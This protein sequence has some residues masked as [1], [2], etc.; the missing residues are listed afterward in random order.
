M[1]S[2]KL[3]LAGE[4]RVSC[5]AGISLPQ[6]ARL[7]SLD[8]QR[9]IQV[10][11]VQFDPLRQPVA[12][13]LG[14]GG[15]FDLPAVLFET[16]QAA[17]AIEGQAAFAVRR[18][19]SAD[20]PGQVGNRQLPAKLLF[21][22]GIRGRRF[23]ATLVGDFQGNLAR[24]SGQARRPATQG[25]GETNVV[26]I[27]ALQPEQRAAAGIFRRTDAY[28]AVDLPA[29]KARQLL[30]VLA[31]LGGVSVA[32][33][34]FAGTEARTTGEQGNETENDEVAQKHN[35]KESLIRSGA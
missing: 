6:L 24:A 3:S 13:L 7:P 20:P 8:H 1:C 9:D 32:L 25:A 27:L 21:E 30:F 31:P 22:Q 16:G 2:I 4:G 26:V 29:I 5:L 12:V 18:R 17:I 11:A 19:Q 15:V 35:L 33:D 14:V 23:V 34:R 10:G 28:L